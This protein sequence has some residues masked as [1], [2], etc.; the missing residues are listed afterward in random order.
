[1]SPPYIP[2]KYLRAEKWPISWGLGYVV[3]FNST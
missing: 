3:G 2:M 1:M